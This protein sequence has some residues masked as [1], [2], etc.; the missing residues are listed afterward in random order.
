M[1]D[2]TSTTAGRRRPGHAAGLFDI[3]N[4]IG[5]LLGIDGLILLLAGLFGDTEEDKTGGVNANLWAGLV[6][7]VVGI[8]FIAWAR[9][10]PVVV[11]DDFETSDDEDRPPG[12]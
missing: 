5:A 8:I 9:L 7:L 2:N 4:I 10:R 12:H 3:R 11:P 1:S 6:L